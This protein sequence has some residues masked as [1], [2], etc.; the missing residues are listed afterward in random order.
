MLNSLTSAADPLVT[1]AIP[2]FNRSA[3]VQ[4]CVLSALAQTY[5]HFEVVVSDNASTDATQDVLKEFQDV[6]LRVVRQPINIGLIGNWNACLAAASGE[7]IVFVSDDDRIAPQ[8]LEQ[9]VSL[10]RREPAIRMVMALV[11][12]N[13]VSK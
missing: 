1:I 2:T 7:F 3:W 10:V 4:D 13:L 9:C 5:E 6:R 12:T 11:D 8:M